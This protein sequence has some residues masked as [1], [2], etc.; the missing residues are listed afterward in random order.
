MCLLPPGLPIV[1][2]CWGS[3]TP[4]FHPLH[5]RTWVGSME[6]L[7]LVS[8]KSPFAFLAHQSQTWGSNSWGW[9][10]KIYKWKQ[11]VRNPQYHFLHPYAYLHRENNVQIIV[12]LDHYAITPWTCMASEWN[13]M[14]KIL[15]LLLL[16]PD[17]WFSANMSFCRGCWLLVSIGT[18]TAFCPLGEC[19]F[20]G[21]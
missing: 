11:T 21:T 15:L 13:A 5:F 7:R 2:W 3:F 1:S 18:S 16:V 8:C 20:N 17:M 6:I 19:F 12:A 14:G 10:V 9:W 4:L